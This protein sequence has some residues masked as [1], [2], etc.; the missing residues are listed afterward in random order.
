MQYSR[1][2]LNTMFQSK[3]YMKYSLE[4]ITY[5]LD[6]FRFMQYCHMGADQKTN[7]DF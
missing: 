5:I 2:N 7:H 6:F 4:N 3:E 1:D